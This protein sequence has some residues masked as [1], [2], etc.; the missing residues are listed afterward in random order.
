MMRRPWIPLVLAA[1]AGSPFARPAAAAGDLNRV[2]HILV[3]M[4]ENHSFDNYFGALPYMPGSPYHLPP[5]AAGGRRECPADD[6]ACLD[7]LTCA[8]SAAGAPVCMNS[9][10][11]R[12]DAPVSAFHLKTRCVSPDLDHSWVGTHRE[13]DFF[14]PAL[15]LLRPR[16]DGFV[17]VN[18]PPESAGDEGPFEDETMGFFTE[19]DLPLYYDLA[20]TFAISDRFFASVP[21]P[22]FP[23]RSY[24]LA[25]TSFGHLTTNDTAPPPGGYRPVHGTIFDRLDAAGVSWADYFQDLPQGASFRPFAGA[26]SEARFLPLATLLDQLAGAPDAAPLPE[27]AFVDPAF[28]V[29]GRA[30]EN[31]EH[32]PTDI[33]RGQ[34]FVSGIVN[35][36]R[37]GPFWEDSILIVTYDEHGGFYDHA[38]PPAAPQG[39]AR[40]P[41][42]VFPGQCADLS[43]PP[44]SLSPG[45]GARCASNVLGRLDTSVTDAE[46]LC[47]ALLGDPT[48][49]YPDRCPAFDQ[50]GVRVP[51]LAVSPFARP[52]YVSH[53]VA[54]HTSILALIESRFLP[55]AGGGHDAL[56]ARDANASTL[57]DLFDFDAAPSRDA[58]VGTAAPPA[59][60]CTP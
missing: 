15:A 57:E 58:I 8:A 59:D 27:V 33:Q 32:P 26:G 41:D 24:L 25:A 9:N 48:G 2:H 30:R 16:N 7:G 28:G 5:P 40:T 55:L 46:R 29:L 34:A 12:D 35:A 49:P 37:H 19:S 22:T 39:G 17:R 47:P 4:Q 51:F 52:A 54:D 20:R 60:D 36:L 1:A 18:D 13:V 56:T 21:G 50:L 11:D 23:N 44:A 31:D 6:H 10:P 43:N 53:V 14:L 3:L 45:A 42:G 38:A